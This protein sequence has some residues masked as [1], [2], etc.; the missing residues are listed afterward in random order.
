MISVSVSLD[1]GQQRLAETLRHIPGAIGKAV[2]RAIN[3]AIEGA[4]TDAVR[5]ICCEYAISPSEVRKRITIV[6]ANTRKLEAQIISTGNPLSLMKFAVKPKQV[7]KRAQ[8]YQV[9]AGVKFG[10]SIEIPHAFIQKMKS[11]HV[12]V[13][14]R[15]GDGDA[16]V[17][18]LP[19]EQLYAPSFPQ[20]LGNDE[21]L[22]YIEIKA[23]HRLDKELRHQITYLLGGGR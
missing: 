3:K 10:N 18:R 15:A 21:V 6:R 11:G 2:S 1:E 17:K 5:R 13:F 4:R 8:R 12:G 7:R 23:H 14:K 9:Y 19:I 16:L 22:R 20:M